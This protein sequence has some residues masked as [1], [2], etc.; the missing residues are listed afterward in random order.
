M[1][2]VGGRLVIVT[3][4]SLEDRLVKA[5]LRERSGKGRMPNRHTPEITKQAA[6]SFSLLNNRVIKPNSQE[7]KRNPRSRSARLRA[8]IRTAA[9]V[10]PMGVFT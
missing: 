10:W 4:H 8:A 6:P 5:F 2:S 9:P 1:L 3:F 7:I